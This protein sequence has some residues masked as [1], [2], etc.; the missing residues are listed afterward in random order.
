MLYALRMHHSY[1]LLLIRSLL[2]TACATAACGGSVAD[3]TAQPAPSATSSSPQPSPLPGASPSPLPGSAQ[4]SSDAGAKPDAPR[5][6]FDAGSPHCDR[7]LGG[8]TLC[9]VDADC[10]TVYEGCYCGPRPATGRSASIASELQSC[11]DQ[12]KATCA[13]RCMQSPGFATD[14]G[15][16]VATD[17][18]R[19]G[20]ACDQTGIVGVCYTFTK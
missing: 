5:P 18:T 1:A 7:P 15:S 6:T 9:N 16:V 10:T 4:S 19:V 13:I 3:P 2:V 12:K 17:T 14:R 20:V 11:E 8:T